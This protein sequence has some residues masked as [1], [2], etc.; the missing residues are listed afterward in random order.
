VSTADGLTETEA[1]YAAINAIRELSSSI[2]IP[3]GLTELG[4][5]TEDLAI[6]AENA[7]KMHVC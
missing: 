7:Q 1:A 4:V 5:K 2:S 3:S 6:M